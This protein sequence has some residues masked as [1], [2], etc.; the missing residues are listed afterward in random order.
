M[1]KRA[2]VSHDPAGRHGTRETSACVKDK[3]DVAQVRLADRVYGV[4]QNITFQNAAR[5]KGWTP[6]GCFPQVG[7]SFLTR[8]VQLNHHHASF[9]SLLPT[10]SQPTGGHYVCK[11]DSTH[12]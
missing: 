11:H 2:T 1:V 6:L 9:T 3:A 10:H 5:P 4:R 8:T 12:G 7:C